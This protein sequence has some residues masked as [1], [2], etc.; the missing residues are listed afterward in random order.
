[1]FHTKEPSLYPDQGGSYWGFLHNGTIILQVAF[2]DPLFQTLW[3]LGWGRSRLKRLER[4]V[5]IGYW[6]WETGRSW[7]WNPGFWFGCLVNGGIIGCFIDYTRI[8]LGASQWSAF[9]TSW[10]WGANGIFKCSCLVTEWLRA[11]SLKKDKQGRPQ[12]KVETIRK[13]VQ[14]KRPRPRVQIPGEHQLSG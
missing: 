13:S 1:M 2:K 8:D 12:V 11:S 14:W 3:Q 9:W 5:L 10:Y 6:E 7:G 4:G